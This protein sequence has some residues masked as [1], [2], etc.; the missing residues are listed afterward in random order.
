MKR[1][2]R[3]WMYE[4][5]DENNKLRREFAKG[6]I[7]FLD[8]AKNDD[9]F[10]SSGEI[11]CPCVNCRNTAF[12]N[13]QDVKSHLARWGF[14]SN[15]YNWTSHGEP[16]VPVRNNIIPNHYRSMV[17]DALL[18][19]V[20]EIREEAL[21]PSYE[22]ETSYQ[23]APNPRVASFFEMLRNAEKPIYEGS[24]MNVLQSA[25]RLLQ[26]KCEFNLPHRC[27]DGIASL[28]GDVVP[29]G[30]SVSRNFYETKKVLKALELPHEK[31]D[32]CVNGC[33]LFWQSNARKTKCDICGQGR[34]KEPNRMRQSSRKGKEVV[35]ENEDDED[36]DA[37]VTGKKKKRDKRRPRN[38]VTY[39]PVGPRLERFYATKHIAK[40]MTWHHENPRVNGVMAHPSD[41]EA[42]KHF[43][44]EHPDFAKEPR[45]VRLGLCT[46][47]F[48]PYGKFGKSYS[49]W[50]V[51]VTPYNLP[52]WLCMKKQ[53]IMLALIV[54]GPKHT[55][56]KMDVYLQPL[57][58]ELKQLWEE[59]IW[60]YDVS[61]KQNFLLRAAVMWTINDFP[62]YGVLSGWTTQGMNACPY[63]FG[64]D[65]KSFHLENSRKYCWFDCHRQFLPMDHE[66]RWNCPHFKK[67]RL[68]EDNEACV[69]L[70]GLETWNRVKDLPKIVGSTKQ[71]LIKQKEKQDGW[72]KQ[73]IFW[74]LPYW[75]TLLIRHNLD[76][77]HIEKN[78][79]EMLIHT[80]MDEPSKT[81]FGPM[82][83][84]DLKI[85]CRSRNQASKRF[86]LNKEQKKALCEWVCKLKFPDGYASDLSRCVD[87][88]SLRLHGM[89]SHDCHVFMERLLPVALKD[90]VPI[91]VWNA[92]T[93]ISQ[94]FR[95]LC[96]S[97]IRVDAMEDLESRIVEIL[98]KFEMIFPPSFFNPMEHLPVHLPYE[99][100]LGG[101]VQYRWMYVFER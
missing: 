34:F 72:W 51:M 6:V 76:A 7:E 1:S 31:I 86:V 4:R 15:Y 13:L 78:F 70:S 95:D 11:R 89:K 33:M 17:E 28:I 64:K 91:R 3:S 100:K 27:V 66:F 84:K 74:E 14:C 62:A 92:I 2:E 77:M 65:N 61:R 60:A 46:D 97:T 80:V 71:Q 10:K 25:A 16:F 63:C 93:E 22:G 87:L 59:G 56:A 67:S 55:K 47:G 54:P 81:S 58:H 69:R 99:A 73:S 30:H 37:N 8:F 32:A 29:K 48:E 82:G 90:L 68:N 23:E 52:P 9:S 53:F 26:L 45:N 24:D 12:L 49:C 40:L 43:D 42:W 88:N 18:E 98:C 20:N 50:P 94:F 38:V 35:V 83:K 96:A 39:F 85:H 57:I 36:D 41:G 79:F 44:K 101:P 19:S 5:L 75:K 21:N